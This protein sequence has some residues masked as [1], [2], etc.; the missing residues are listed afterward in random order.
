M[1]DKEIFKIIGLLLL[2]FGCIA[3]IA[4]MIAAYVMG[5]ND[6]GL[7]CNEMFGIGII[8]LAGIGMILGGKVF[9]SYSRNI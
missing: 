3:E 2:A 5:F 8:C 1:T 7:V 4:S 9:L 6:K